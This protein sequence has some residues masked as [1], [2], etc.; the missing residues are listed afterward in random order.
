M[1]TKIQKLFTTLLVLPLVA[2]LFGGIA[3][4][5]DCG[6]EEECA[7]ALATANTA[8]AAATKLDDNFSKCVNACPNIGPNDWTQCSILIDGVSTK[9]NTIYTEASGKTG[10]IEIAKISAALKVDKDT[11]GA[12]VVDLQ[13]NAVALKKVDISE[14]L[15]VNQ[16]QIQSDNLKT[17]MDK[18][19]DLLVKMVGL[20]AFVFLVIGGF[21]LI[22]AAGND[23]QIQK[24]KTM[25]TYSIA[26]LVI[27]LLAY[28]I[29]ALVQGLLY[30]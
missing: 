25:I 18:T 23:N 14:I 10:E 17:F 9:C 19:I 13:S 26:G 29:I 22:A 12:A 1:K 16:D 8:L 24:A 3:A 5:V 30:R 21:R 11:L 28:I 20:V 27:V 15:S 6:T 4:A 2:L 7:A